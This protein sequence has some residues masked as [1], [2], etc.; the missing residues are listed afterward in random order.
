M[1]SVYSATIS[2]REQNISKLNVEESRKLDFI[3]Y[4]KKIREIN[5]KDG[6]NIT[7]IVCPFC[8]H[9]YTWIIWKK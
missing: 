1:E 6:L 3:S 7:K 2:Y 8:V 9:K 4:A 5:K